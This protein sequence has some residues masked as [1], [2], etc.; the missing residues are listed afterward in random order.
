MRDCIVH[1]MVGMIC[2]KCGKS[3]RQISF[4]RNE[5]KL[6]ELIGKQI[7]VKIDDCQPVKCG[8]VTE[9]NYESDNELGIGV[10]SLRQVG[11]GKICNSD[12]TISAFPIHKEPIPPG[13]MNPSI[14]DP[15]TIR[16][17]RSGI[18]ELLA[19]VTKPPSSVN[20]AE[21]PKPRCI[22]CNRPIAKG[23]TSCEECYRYALESVG[24]PIHEV[25]INAHGKP[26]Q[27]GVPRMEQV[28]ELL[29]KVQSEQIP[30][31][32]GLAASSPCPPLHL[33]PTVG[34][35]GLAERFQKGI[36]RKGDKA[37]N[38]I[39]SNQ[40]CLKD[41]EFAIERLSHVVNH[42]MKLRDKLINSDVKAI[43]QD[44]DAGAIAW[45]GIFLL[46]VVDELKK[47][48]K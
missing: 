16:P 31:A 40:A 39:S 37:W 47:E 9:V 18:D 15:D 2:R 10:D 28:Y 20:A 13:V 34:L 7:T 46:C 36:E 45:A 32:G 35:I 19:P 8:V 41:K 1:E 6:S 27:I 42:A 3:Q 26:E 38:A 11:V 48:K 22:I 24:A 17:F 30:M 23:Q 44:D 43:E 29:R 12:G 21:L 25:K 4:E 5:M 14:V 33:I